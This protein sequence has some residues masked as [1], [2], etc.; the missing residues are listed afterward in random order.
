MAQGFD[1]DAI[2]EERTR[3]VRA[4]PAGPRL[5]YEY[6]ERTDFSHDYPATIKEYRSQAPL[7]CAHPATKDN[8]FAGCCQGRTLLGR[9]CGQEHCTRCETACAECGVSISRHCCARP[10]GIGD[11]AVFLCRR[12]TAWRRTKRALSTS[13]SFLAR[14]FVEDN[15]SD[16]W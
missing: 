3:Y 13:A 12:C 14:P 10:H 16:A 2:I 9:V 6:V 5:D 15:A 4:T 11:Q 1:E 8:P 7:A